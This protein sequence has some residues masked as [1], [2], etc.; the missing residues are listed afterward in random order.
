MYKRQFDARSRGRFAGTDPEPRAGL[1]GGHIPNSV[2][3]PFTELL[4][5]NGEL[6]SNDELRSAFE[7]IGLLDSKPVITSCGSGVT[8]AILTL[9]LH[10]IG[11]DD[12]AIYDGS[13][14]EWG[15]RSDLPVATT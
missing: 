7:E 8:A 1:R 2:C 14:T 13:W 15:G 9:A 6:K 4:D 10:C 3:M 12:C 5:N 11:R